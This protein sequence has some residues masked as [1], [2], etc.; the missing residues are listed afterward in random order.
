MQHR[1]SW[2]YTVDTLEAL[3]T[4]RGE[5]E[6]T[7]ARK[8]TF[9]TQQASVPV[10]LDLA[11]RNTGATTLDQLELRMICDPPVLGARTWLFE[12]LQPG[13]E[14]RVRDRTVTLDGGRLIRLNEAMLARLSLAL[15]RRDQPDAAPIATYEQDIEALA[16]N[17]W[18]GASTMPEL[19][20]SFIMPNDPAIATLLR[21]TSA[22]LSSA[23][24][25]G[26]L[27]AYQSQSRKRV[28]ELTSA[29]WSAVCARKLTYVEPPASFER[30][31]QK[32][33]TPSD[34]LGQ[35]LATCLDTAVLFAAALEQMGLNPVVVMLEGHA[36]AGAW[37]QPTQ[38]GSL[39]TED[40]IDVRKHL[41][42]HELVLFETTLVTTNTPTS[43]S[44]TI[45][46]A[47]RQLDERHE[48][49]FIY[50][51]D[52]RQARGRLIKPLPM[53]LA[54]ATS[55]G[56]HGPAVALSLEEAPDLPGFDGLSDVVAAPDTPQG[57]IAHW[58]RKLLDLT[59]RNRLLNLKT[60]KTTIPMIC[61]DPAALED[62]LADREKVLI[63]PIP[64]MVG[65]ETNRDSEVFESQTKTDYERTFA[66]EA[67]KRHEL[68]TPVEPT[69]LEAGLIELYRKA[70]TD[71]QEG[72]ANTL[73]LAL[74]V[75]R[76]RPLGS[77]T[78]SY[79]APLLLVPVTLKRKSA[80]SRMELSLHDDEPT[81]N[82]TLLEMLRQDFELTIP[83]LEGEL[84]R[85]RSGIDVQKVW[86]RVRSAVRDVP[87][88]EVLGEVVLS[89]FSFAKYLMWKDLSDRT[90]QLKN[91]A[92]VRHLI[93]HPRNAY[94][95]SAQFLSP[96]E[97]DDT[98]D[99]ASLFMPLTADSS[100]VVAVHAS[101]LEG[102]FV[103]EGPPGTGKSQ[104]I[105]N[106]IAHN[107][108]LG[109]RVLFVAEKMVALDVVYERL[110]KVGLG[111][112][113]LELHSNKASKREVLNQLDSS[114]RGR[115]SK[116]PAA[117]NTEAYRLKQA[118]DRL[119]I[120]VRTLH[121]PGP[122]GLSPREAVARA[123]GLA[124]DRPVHLGWLADL[125]ADRA[126]DPE[127][128]ERLRELAHR[129]G[130]AFSELTAQDTAD[131][132]AITCKDWSNQW[133]SELAVKAADL[134][135]E[136]PAA[137]LRAERFAELIAAPV[138]VDD[139]ARTA[140]LAILAQALQSAGR[141]HA[142]A[143][144][145]DGRAYLDQLEQACIELAAYRTA[146][147]TL[148]VS[149]SDDAVRSVDIDALAEEQRSAASAIWPVRPIRQ[150]LL[151][152]RAAK[153]FGLPSR[154]DLASDLPILEQMQARLA[155]LARL[156]DPLPAEA[157]WMGLATDL[158]AMRDRIT[159]A[160]ALRTA[161]TQLGLAPVDAARF[162]EGLRSLVADPDQMESG[163]PLLAGAADLVAAAARCTDTVSAFSRLA[164]IQ[165]DNALSFA[166]LEA[167]GAAVID[168]Q[169]RL[170]AWCR[171]QALR[172]ACEAQGLG[173]IVEGLMSGA[174]EAS[175]SQRVFDAAYARW[176]A[177]VLIDSRPILRN[178]SPG[179]HADLINQFRQLD[180]RLADLSAAHIRAKLSSNLPSPDAP[181]RDSGFGVLRHEAQK[182]KRHKPVRQLIAEMGQAL[183]RLTPCLLMSPLSVAQ[184]LDANCEPFDLVIFDEASQITVWDA[185]G[186]IA[187]GRNAIIVGDPKQ[188]PPTSFF[189]RAAATDDDS[190]DENSDLESILDEAIAASVRHHRLTGHY[191]SRHESLIAFSNH[192]YYG[193]DLVTF[194]AA[195]TKKSAVSLVRCDG[196]W[197]RG[198]QERTNPVEAK[199]VV[200][201]VVRRLLDPEL[202]R[203]SIGVVTFNADQQRLILNLLDDERR[204]RPALERFFGE[205]A[206]DGAV[207]VKNLESVQGDARDVVML[208]IGF[209]PTQPGARTM[210]MDFGALNREGGGRRLNVAITRATTEVLVFASFD[211]DMI[212]LA[213]TQSKAVRDLKDYL[214]FALRGPVALG[215]AITSSVTTDA[216][217]SPFEEAVARALRARNWTV[218]TQVGISRFKIDLG[219]VHPD[220]PG[221][222]LAGVECDGASY[223]GSPT[224]RDRDRVRQSVLEDL[225]WSLIRIWSTDY[226]ND[227]HRVI[228][229]VDAR[230]EALLAADRSQREAQAKTGAAATGPASPDDTDPPSAA[231]QKEQE[232]AAETGAG[233]DEP[234]AGSKVQPRT[235][236]ATPAVQRA[237]PAPSMP[238]PPTVMPPTVQL[239]L[240]PGPATA[241]RSSVYDRLSPEQFGDPAYERVLRTLCAELIDYFGPITFKYLAEKVARAHGFLRTGSQIKKSVWASAIR[242]R[243]H[244]RE[245]DFSPTF[246]PDR[247]A[248]GQLHPYRGTQ[249]AGET[250]AWV[251][252]PL[253][254]RRALAREIASSPD[255]TDP[256]AAMA[257]RIGLGRLREGT[258]RELE[259]LIRDQSKGLDK[260]G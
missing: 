148:S 30:S 17:E 8:V 134:L 99:P 241:F 149:W 66:A 10:I 205:D 213:R 181:N 236:D 32:I 210:Y 100:Q 103:L 81:F 124:T 174:V 163:T 237:A 52:V 198:G 91:S 57:R 128:L 18:G 152:G 151:P 239:E 72:G 80:T 68:A 97:L 170:N 224:A 145:A 45:E 238:A 126:G 120:V 121:E 93:D 230:L 70:N 28:W 24:K 166:E 162:R 29:L 74:G 144:M 155:E 202:S 197:Q 51:L 169:P 252:V 138:V 164:V 179:E 47:K 219:I 65:G 254:E 85:D 146:R 214:N 231:R 53:E 21:E 55:T 175:A 131:F 154:P 251:D 246:W 161:A 165:Q 255:L 244:T 222:Y 245:A 232:A 61:P 182:Q 42:S 249:V 143:L 50:A 109:R 242:A 16:R 133:S 235:E 38:F 56:S 177:P 88:F 178:F 111:D 185:I 153:N 142:F 201:E 227:P 115:T 20:A 206:G 76:W 79:K 217:D 113:C 196:V 31:G 127:G 114:W 15:V 184:F 190:D 12:R 136:V 195:D 106:I 253:P 172:Q 215:A 102:D 35:G 228:A 26:R 188:M 208:S 125:S 258:R 22:I 41:G 96:E 11:I 122:T 123:A 5:I 14:L 259:D 129:L 75:L 2:G 168:R 89:T 139:L 216:Y 199:A 25:D 82:L 257:A 221:R 137:R 48:G 62:M 6:A 240:L 207:M 248:S 67:L 176:L 234:P 116:S 218:H 203:Y 229:Q 44:Q 105:A 101:G 211:P 247:M 193:G 209:G 7:I 233:P 200:Q 37:L 59:K 108:G 23:G 95:N 63:T 250:R 36:L 189:N 141:M 69:K 73:F 94:G 27:D 191:R 147:E 150:W 225:G 90:D 54:E 58:K 83:E 46:S 118:R 183:H 160:R 117:W 60:G 220:W 77:E 194:P 159:C 84:P 3:A 92:L 180:K 243:K 86:D 64:A 140:S 256:A 187:R 49:R 87:G 4:S 223:H 158:Q 78:Q 34:V 39:T 71:M 43:F 167:L 104:T 173:A 157:G 192:R 33:R 98:V 19:L 110:K 107:L 226:F 156:T 40:P 260:M 9:A 130:Q 135:K 132:S 186:A 13:A 119:N 204:A 171:W 112:L 1:S 212:D